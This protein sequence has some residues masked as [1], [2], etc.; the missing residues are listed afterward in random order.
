M[1]DIADVDRIEESRD[2][3]QQ[4]F[5]EDSLN[6]VPF[7]IMANKID[8]PTALSPT[9]VQNHLELGK[10]MYDR[11]VQLA[12]VSLVQKQGVKEAFDWLGSQLRSK[13]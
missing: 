7:L 3:L 11:K 10:V 2:A 9:E 1:V 13:K 6:D 4:L 8:L 5:A 12:M